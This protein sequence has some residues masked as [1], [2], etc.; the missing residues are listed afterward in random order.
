MDVRHS[1]DHLNGR[2]AVRLPAVL[3]EKAS[4]AAE[5]VLGHGIS[6]KAVV[7]ARGVK[8]I[9]AAEREELVA[10][11]LSFLV[12][13]ILDFGN[14]SLGKELVESRTANTVVNVVSGAKCRL[15]MLVSK[16]CHTKRAKRWRRK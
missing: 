14:S 6:G 2:F 7:G 16:S 12:D 1:F 11:Q 8:R 4:T 3:L 10:E 13:E 9:A 15:P 5:A